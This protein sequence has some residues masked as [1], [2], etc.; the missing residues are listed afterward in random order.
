MINIDPAG[1]L[2]QSRGIE[3]HKNVRTIKPDKGYAA[4]NIG[5]LRSNNQAI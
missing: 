5:T 4:A 1:L 3:H 2:L